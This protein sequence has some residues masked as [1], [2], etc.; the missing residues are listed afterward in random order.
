MGAEAVQDLGDDDVEGVLNT[1]LHMNSSL[2]FSIPGGV[3]GLQVSWIVLDKHK[4]LQEEQQ[5]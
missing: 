4:E 1:R 2:L 3:T 5:H